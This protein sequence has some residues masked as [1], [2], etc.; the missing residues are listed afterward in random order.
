M[1][2]LTI[3]APFVALTYPID[4]LNDGQAQGFNKWLKEYIFNLL[5]QPLHLFLYTM[6]VSSAFEFAGVNVWYMLVSIGF[7]IPAEKLLRSFFGFEKAVTPGSFAGAAVG[8]GLISRG[9]G[10]LLHK[11]PMPGGPGKPGLGK[12]GN[13]DKDGIEGMAT[14]TRFK[15][16]EFN[17]AGEICKKNGVKRLDLF[18]S[19]A[20]GTATPV[21]DID[22]VVYGCSDIFKLE[23][24][25][26]D[27]PTLRKIDIFEFETIH[28]EFLLEDIKKYGKQIY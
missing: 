13:G 12:G 28:N 18:G 4:K 20:T 17:A 6:L 11:M 23:D 14:K 21:S 19:F 7:L 16:D 27:I 26:A 15:A 5:I 8:A 25:L 3:I 9:I 1:A 24:E 10:G 22:F 2:F